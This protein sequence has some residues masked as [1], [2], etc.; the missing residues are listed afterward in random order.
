MKPLRPLLAAAFLVLAPALRAEP[1]IL[2]ACVGDSITQGIGTPQAPDKSFPESYPAQLAAILGEGYA[3]TNFGVGGRTLL[4]KADPYGYGRALQ[5]GGKIIVI[6]LGTNDSKPYA[7]DA[8]GAEFESDYA[9]MVR[10]FQ[11][12]PEMPRILL[13]LPPP[14]FHGGQWGIREEILHS[15]IRPAILRVAESC[16]VETIDLATPLSDADALFPDRVHPNPAGARQIAGLVAA[17]IRREDAP[18]PLPVVSVPRLSSPPAIDG[19]TSDPAWAAAAVIDGLQP[20]LDPVP[21]ASALQRTSVRIAWEPTALYVAFECA[22]SD[23]L[24]SGT[25]RRDDDLSRE[26]AVEVFLDPVGDGRA[27]FEFQVAPDG[28]V[29]DA[30][31]L[32]TATPETLGDGR[33]RP[34]I[35]KTDRWS[36]REWDLPDYEAAAKRTPD[37]WTAEL[38]I[39]AAPLMRRLGRERLDKRVAPRAQFVRCDH[40]GPAFFQQYWSPCMHGNPH[41]SPARFGTLR[42]D[43]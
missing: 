30:V 34:E 20:P 33:I 18:K 11:S 14:V 41:N 1:P 26:D 9:K 29:F 5:A 2:V 12:C 13:C 32:Y 35:A 31:H 42:L 4:R 40:D 39:P 10:D 3:V 43:P 6:G 24:C 23:V 16:G 8:H 25:M 27:F 28:T 38:R 17:A 7:W 15:A 36:M 22:D 37:G 21:G 19:D